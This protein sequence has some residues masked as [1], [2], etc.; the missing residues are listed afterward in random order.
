MR[1]KQ[2]SLGARLV[3]STGFAIIV[4]LAVCI[5]FFRAFTQQAGVVREIEYRDMARSDRIGL[6]VVQLSQNQR[7][8]SETLAAAVDR[9]L[10]EEQ[11][12][13]AGRRAIDSVRSISKQFSALRPLFEGDEQLLSAFAAASAEINTYRSTVIAVVEICT[14]NA[15]QAPLQM[16][17]A[18]ASYVRLVDHMSKI[19]KL[20]DDQVGRA[21]DRML[22][23][24][25]GDNQYLLI[26]TA[27][28]LIGLIF[29]SFVFYR[30]TRRAEDE[31]DR[32]KEF[33]DLVVEN[34]PVTIAV[35]DARDLRYMLVNRAGE[36]YYDVPREK[37][38]GKTAQEALSPEYADVVTQLDHKMLVS[39]PTAESEVAVEMSNNGARVG[40]AKRLP[41]FD[42]DGSAKYLLSVI[43]DVTERKQAEQKIAHMAHHDM[44]TGLANRALFCDELDRALVR[45]RRGERIAV[46]Y[47]DLDHFKR[48][49]DT[50]GH[51]VGDELLRQAADRLRECVRDSDL[52]A[53]LGGDEFAI[54]QAAVEEPSDA[55]ALAARIHQALT[56]PF[57][58]EDHQ[59]VAG[60]SVGISIAPDDAAEQQ[61]LL[62][63]ADLA[64]YGAKEGGRGTYHF[65][66]PELDAR[67]KTRHQLEVDLRT[68][69]VQGQFELHY[70]PIVNLR[71]NQ[72]ICCEALLRWHHPERGMVSPGEFVPVA[73]DC[74]MITALGEWVLRQACADASAWPE[75]VQVAVNV[76][77]AQVKAGN[78]V[79]LA[80]N[81]LAAS[82]LSPNRLVVEITESM[83]MQNTDAAMATLHR[84][85]DLGVAIA[86]DDFGTG[87]SS[88]SYLRSFPFDKIKIDRSFI[89]SIPERDDCVA[90][91]Q[92]VTTMAERLNMTTVAE[93]IETVDQ[94][95]KLRELGCTAMQGFLFSRPKPV[96]ECIEQ[97]FARPEKSTSAA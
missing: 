81:A 91:V 32:G 36:T 95:Q 63:Y 22:V 46:L 21:L 87:Y 2:I 76:S 3:G 54:L 11:I 58:L 35:K 65:Y 26:G 49:N 57:Q 41:I 43:D 39:G 85:R 83:L 14:A 7:M 44:L 82:G 31:R 72:V 84:L 56:A 50:F 64:L 88:L 67:M 78:L 61:V 77:P 71:T 23:K 13:E 27:V 24:A 12:F 16:L 90:I 15:A 10:D 69:L 55:A 94:R 34:V 92:A 37:M 52:I 51:L 66:Q 42:K 38:I 20:T 28:A 4:L 47:L 17:K 48:V 60:V 8:L 70:Q 29:A 40:V 96:R 6:L 25:K 62:K 68:A 5:G 73:E 53:R 30:G 86:M 33:L 1:L 74:G 93:G 45:V 18:S 59:V 79:Q 75:D 89:E 9:K 80:V 19:T 97:F